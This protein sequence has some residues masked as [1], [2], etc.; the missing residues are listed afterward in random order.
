MQ[1]FSIIVP[2]LGD[3]RLLDDTLASVLRYRSES[4]QVVV[5]HDGT[6]DDPYGLEGEIELASISRR[7][8]LIRLF[9]C[10]LSQATGDLIAL[11]RPG[12]EL[13]EGWNDAVESSF[14]DPQVGCVTPLIVTPAEPTV[15]VAA[16]VKKGFGFRRQLVGNQKKLA[17]RTLR[18]MAPAGPTSW[19]AFYRRSALDQL[20]PIDEQLDPHYL[21][22]EIA[23]GLATLGYKNAISEDCLV[24]AERAMLVLRESE[25]PHGKSA[26]RALRRHVREN[27][28]LGV[29]AQS[30]CALVHEIITSPLQPSRFL[31][32]LQRLT[33]WGW[34]SDD[35]E[36]A[37]RLRIAAETNRRLNLTGLRIRKPDLTAE[38]ADPGKATSSDFDSQYDRH[39]A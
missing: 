22:L 10:G 36:F 35:R 3:R 18:R 30:A 7:S 16:G 13:D 14:A 6:Y 24:D 32:A 38:K 9:N 4:C 26:Q 5:V 37:D 39:A 23:L 27:G 12:V 19:A 28:S 2:V 21:D 25:L 33:T 1:R 34:A 15:M 31:H 29:L 20:G 17:P 8:Q 11:I